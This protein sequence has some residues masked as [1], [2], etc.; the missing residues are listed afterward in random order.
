MYNCNMVWG[1][2]VNRPNST[3]LN[4]SARRMRQSN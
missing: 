1:K 2:K 4:S 3:Y